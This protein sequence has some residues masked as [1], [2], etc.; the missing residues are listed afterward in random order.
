MSNNTPLT[1]LRT[2]AAAAR[3]SSFT[4]AAQE[5]HLTQAA[6]SKHM[7]AL[8]LHVG[9]TLFV[10]LAHGIQLTELGS[11]YQVEVEAALLALD[12]A[13]YDLFGMGD[14]RA[15]NLHCNMAFSHWWLIPR[16]ADFYALYPQVE[17]E[18][19]H[20]IWDMQNEPVK[21]DIH[22]RYGL[23]EWPKQHTLRLTD[24]ELIPMVAS[25]LCLAE[26]QQLPLIHVLGYRH[27][28]HWYAE[29]TQQEQLL[30]KAQRKVDNS[31][32]AYAMAGQ[33]LGI[34]LVRSSFIEHDWIKQNLQPLGMP[35][36]KTPEG[37]FA[38]LNE[39]SQSN[40]QVTKVW[41]WLAAIA[42]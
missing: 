8:E 22:V 30:N 7:R 39:S 31:V 3:L 36:G 42:H 12:H 20:S 19:N 16:L 40:E 38:L 4:H 14:Q 35:A 37:F 41:H 27:G 23:G 26:A 13:T 6:V 34:V 33:G 5:L 11:R 2:F 1:W 17:V 32:A 10:R 18:L 21:G 29:Q 15:V 24:D 28:W 25:H 9:K